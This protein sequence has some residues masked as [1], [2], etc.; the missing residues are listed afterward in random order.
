MGTTASGLPYPEPTD[1]ASGGAAAIQALAQALDVRGSGLLVQSGSSVVTLNGTG[2]GSITPG[3]AFKTGT[4]PIPIFQVQD[5]PSSLFVVSYNQ[6]TTAS[7][8]AFRMRT[9][10]DAIPLPG[11]WRIGWIAIGV[12]P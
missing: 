7:S 10:A 11:P 12:A 5:P 4:V 2:D 8:L 3:K 6:Y 9:P 1:L